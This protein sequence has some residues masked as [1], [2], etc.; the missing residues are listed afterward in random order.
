MT[1]CALHVEERALTLLHRL[2][3][4]DPGKNGACP[5][6]D[7]HGAARYHCFRASARDGLFSEVDELGP[8]LDGGPEAKVSLHEGGV[9]RERRLRWREGDVVGGRKSLGMSGRNWRR[10]GRI[11]FRNEL[12]K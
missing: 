12:G 7:A 9:G 1:L 11:P 5:R 8:R 2:Q 3:A 6:R 10:G 4:L